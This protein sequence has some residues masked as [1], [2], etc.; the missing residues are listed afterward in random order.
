MFDLDKARKLME[1]RE[2]DGLIVSSPENF[3]Y[4]SDYVGMT[5]TVGTATAIIPKSQDQD[6]VVIV[7]DWEIEEAREQTWIKDVRTF[8]TWIYFEKDGVTLPLAKSKPEQ[9]DPFQVV[10]D[11]LAEKSIDEGKLGVELNV[12][13]VTYFEKLR[14]AIPKA[15]LVNANDL[16]WEMRSVKSPDEVSI[17]KEA[18]RIHEKGIRA[19]VKVAKE[20][21][22]EKEIANEFRKV[23]IGDRRYCWGIVAIFV[24]GGANSGSPHHT[25]MTPSNYVLRRGDFL[26]FDGSINFKGYITGIARTYVIGEPSKKQEKLYNALLQ[27][28]RKIVESMKPGVKPSDLYKIGIKTVRESG[29]QQYIRGHLGHSISL[30]PLAQEPPFISATEKG[31]LVPG[32]L[33]CIEVPYYIL[34]LGGVNIEDMIVVTPDG[35]EELTTLSRELSLSS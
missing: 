4:V 18:A 24:G 20:G 31:E 12:I 35:H 23:V 33:F 30:G 14:K 11:V 28:Q 16:F 22:T 29:F 25:F 9:F 6:A 7:L 3:Y 32:M 15:N 8:E 19:A 5:G 2:L 17:I 1:N 10:S 34:G 13:P 27:A 26:K 21:V